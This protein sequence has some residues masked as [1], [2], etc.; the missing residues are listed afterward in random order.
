MTDES[1][2]EFDSYIQFLEKIALKGGRRS[3]VKSELAAAMGNHPAYLSKVFANQ[4]H[5]N[6]EQAEKV[7]DYLELNPH[8]KRYFFALVEESRAGTASLKK[9]FQEERAALKKTH[10]NIKERIPLSNEVPFEEQALYYSA[11]YY[12]AIHVLVSLPEFRTITAIAKRLK[13]SASDVREAVEFLQRLGIIQS[14]EGVLTVGERH[15]HLKQSSPF[16][17]QHHLN[18]RLKS[19]SC[20]DKTSSEDLRYSSILS[21]SEKDAIALK[22][23]MLKHLGECLETVRSSQDERVF[24]YCLDF[25]ELP[26]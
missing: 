26:G 17:R 16:I 20:L 9:Y 15:I 25:F 14:H 1:V 22:E 3:G 24:V 2:F 6:L 5:L 4:A 23:K 11:W 21:L 12:A 13:L 10:L 7:A 18:M 8:E 19:A